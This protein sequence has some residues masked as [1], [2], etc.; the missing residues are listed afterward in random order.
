MSGMIGRPPVPDL[1]GR[2]EAGLPA[3]H[4]IPGLHGIRLTQHL[5]DGPYVPRAGAKADEAVAGCRG[6]VL[7]VSVPV[8]ETKT[9]SGTI[10]VHHV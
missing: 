5:T 8:P 3:V 7:T 4:P 6:G 9:G 1:F 10:P 2:V